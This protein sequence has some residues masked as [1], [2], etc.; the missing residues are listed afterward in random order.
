MEPGQ[1]LDGT[2]LH[3][4][5]SRPPLVAIFMVRTKGRIVNADLRRWL[6]WIAVAVLAFIVIAVVSLS[7]GG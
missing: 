3:G 5:E 2:S 1:E 6:P 7:S 4:D